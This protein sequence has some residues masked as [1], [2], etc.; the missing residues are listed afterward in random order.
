MDGRRWPR[1]VPDRRR[2]PA[3]GVG[4]A[5]SHRRA[6]GQGGCGR[7]APGFGGGGSR[8]SRQCD[9]AGAIRDV[10]C[11]KRSS[12][13]GLGPHRGRPG[14][15]A[16]HSR[17]AQRRDRPACQNGSR[18]LGRSSGGSP[19]SNPGVACECRPGDAASMARLPDRAGGRVSRTAGGRDDPHRRSR[20]HAGE[21]DAR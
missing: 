19:T 20:R 10:P 6:R 8:P 1:L 7:G 3:A 2:E 9:A 17:P 16:I 14:I 4:R 12:S 5:R 13:G 11:R 21:D 18:R 15:A